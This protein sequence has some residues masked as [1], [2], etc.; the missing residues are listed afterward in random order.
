MSSLCS[1]I[2]RFTVK[3]LLMT[4]RQ[5]R[6]SV[7]GLVFWSRYARSTSSFISRSQ[8]YCLLMLHISFFLFNPQSN[9]ISVMRELFFCIDF[10]RQDTPNGFDKFGSA[11][12]ISNNSAISVLSIFIARYS[13]VSIVPIPWLFKSQFW[14]SRVWKIS[15]NSWKLS[16]TVTAICRGVSRLYCFRAFTSKPRINQKY[17]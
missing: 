4:S 13:G 1:P 14:D 16:E 8:E 7:F 10:R 6:C 17:K 12:A 5:H 9:N 3:L 2:L 15:T 11:P